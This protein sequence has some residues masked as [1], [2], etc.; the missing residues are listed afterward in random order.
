MKLAGNYNGLSMSFPVPQLGSI[1]AMQTAVL[2]QRYEPPW[3]CKMKLLLTA[4]S[5]LIR[6]S[7][8]YMGSLASIHQAQVSD[9]SELS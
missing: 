1:G 3:C 7:S 5:A 8:R 9:C 2:E 6:E 4:R